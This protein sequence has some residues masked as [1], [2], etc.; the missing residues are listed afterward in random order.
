MKP[1]VYNELLMTL[2]DLVSYFFPAVSLST[3]RQ[4]L[5]VLGLELYRGNRFVLFLLSF[6]CACV[7]ILTC[8]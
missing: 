5:E 3:C 6:F 2:P 8:Y 4:V 1:Y 7:E